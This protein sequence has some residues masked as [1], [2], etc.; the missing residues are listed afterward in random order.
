MN[1]HFVQHGMKAVFE[2]RMEADSI[3]NFRTGSEVAAG[4]LGVCAIFPRVPWMVRRRK[5][6]RNEAKHMFGEVQ[7]GQL[8]RFEGLCLQRRE[9]CKSSEIMRFYQAFGQLST[10]MNCWLQPARGSHWAT[11]FSPRRKAFKCFRPRAPHARRPVHPR[12]KNLWGALPNPTWLF[13]KT[14]GEKG[15]RK[16]EESRDSWT[17]SFGRF[18]SFLGSVRP[19]AGSSSTTSS[20]SIRASRIWATKKPKPTASRRR[21]R[22][23]TDPSQVWCA[24]KM[25]VKVLGRS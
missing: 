13:F 16:D 5:V 25:L 23:G 17:W 21:E 10:C 20:P 14:E 7:R 1:R 19:V 2:P 18:D 3:N 15:E 11:H 24:R 8:S 22:G 12:S 6:S 9:L 4:F